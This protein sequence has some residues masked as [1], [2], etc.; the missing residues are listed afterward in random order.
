MIPGAVHRSLGIYL[1]AEENSR[2][3][4]LGTCHMKAVGQVFASNGVP[5]LQMRSGESHSTSQ[6]E[7][8]KKEVEDGGRV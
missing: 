7:E 4:Q 2:K 6:R 1:S 8:G 3:P 5:Y